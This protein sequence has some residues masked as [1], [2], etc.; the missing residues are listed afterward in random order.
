M[1]KEPEFILINPNL[2]QN[3]RMTLLPSNLT[4]DSFLDNSI[5]ATKGLKIQELIQDI[6][7]R[8]GVQDVVDRVIKNDNLELNNTAIG[9]VE[10]LDSQ[11]LIKRDKTYEND[12]KRKNSQ[13]FK[14]DN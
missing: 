12:K 3:P 13:S 9:L 5:R 10:F 11:K 14:L 4:P 8:K 2:N 7:K 6:F 1:K